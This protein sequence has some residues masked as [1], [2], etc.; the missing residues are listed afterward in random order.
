MR[1]LQDNNEFRT[2]DEAHNLS[3]REV[4]QHRDKYLTLE[5]Y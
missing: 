4:K 1:D 2:I 3:D 5:G